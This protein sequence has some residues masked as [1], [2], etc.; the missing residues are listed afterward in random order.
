VSRFRSQ[1]SIA[2]ASTAGELLVL[3][4]VSAFAMWSAVS[5]RTVAERAIASSRA[6]TCGADSRPR[7]TT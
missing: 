2:Q 5:T 6:P 1:V 4:G 7:R 3:V